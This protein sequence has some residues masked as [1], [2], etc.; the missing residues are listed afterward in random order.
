MF[1]VKH[2]EKRHQFCKNQ[3]ETQKKKLTK[4]YTIVYK[5]Q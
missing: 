4:R 5:T 2:S 1:I 3:L